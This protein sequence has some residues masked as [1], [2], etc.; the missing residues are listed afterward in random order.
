MLS[1]FSNG[2]Q[3]LAAAEKRLYQLTYHARRI[4]SL[5]E[6]Y[7]LEHIEEALDYCINHELYSIDEITGVLKD[8]YLEIILES[9]ELADSKSTLVRSL[10][11]YDDGSTTYENSPSI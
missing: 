7:P 4:L 10:D 6:L 5:L 1:T 8:K 9:K 11:Y 3:Y 2:K